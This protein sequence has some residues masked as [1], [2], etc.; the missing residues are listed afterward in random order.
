MLK[1]HAKEV[2][3]EV[4]LAVLDVA[5]VSNASGYELIELPERIEEE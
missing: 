5:L 4:A 2:V 1:D 3:E